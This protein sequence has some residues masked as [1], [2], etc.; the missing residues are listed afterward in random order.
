MSKCLPQLVVDFLAYVLDSNQA[1]DASHR[2]SGTS[3]RWN[4]YATR[5]ENFTEGNCRT[6]LSNLMHI[7]W[8]TVGNIERKAIRTTLTWHR[9]KSPN[10]GR[11]QRSGATD[12]V[13]QYENEMKQQT[14]QTWERDSILGGFLLFTMS[15]AIDLQM[16]HNSWDICI[17]A[18]NN[19]IFEL[20]PNVYKLRL[21][22]VLKN[23]SFLKKNADWCRK[24]WSRGCGWM[25][26][27]AAIISRCLW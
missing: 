16:K 1:F 5:P 6:T 25:R 9:W 19:A 26:G 17:V 22:G 13:G 2:V 4:G 24:W 20:I 15:V 18:V 27:K 8:T 7:L 14:K 23:G 12:F 21:G 10:R 3:R 11:C